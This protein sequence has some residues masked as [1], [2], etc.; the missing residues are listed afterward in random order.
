MPSKYRAEASERQQWPDIGGF[1]GRDGDPDVSH[2]E[3]GKGLSKGNVWPL[4]SRRCD[5]PSH[6]KAVESHS[7]IK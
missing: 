7:Q 5:C 2:R 3:R 4:F 1:V 6:F